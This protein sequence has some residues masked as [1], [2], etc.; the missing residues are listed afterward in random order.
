MKKTFSLVLAL[1]MIFSLFSFGTA[2][3]DF[4]AAAAYEKYAGTELNFIRHSGYEADWMA[5]KAQEFYELSGIKVNVEQIAYSE[6]KNKVML[7]VS[8]PGGAYDI[9]ATTEYWLSEFDEGE[10]LVDQYQFINDPALYDPAFEIEDIGAST[11]DSNTIDGKLLAMPFKTNGQFLVYRSDLV[12]EPPTTWEEYLEIAAANT[13]DDTV[14]VSLALSMASGM[15]V[16]LNLLYQAGGS[17]LNE[18]NTACNLDT[19]EAK[20]AMEFLVNL[21]EYTTEGAINNQWPESSAVFAQGG[22]A[23]Y[24]TINSQLSSLYSSASEEVLSSLKYA[25]LPGQVSCIST[26]GLGITS[27]CECPEAAWL[28]IQYMFGPEK[29]VEVVKGTSGSDIP[30]RSSLLLDKE[31]MSAYPHFEVIDQMLSNEGHT[32]V[33]PKTTV[34]TAIMEALATHVQNA[35]IGS[36]TVDEALANAKAEIDDLLQDA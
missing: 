15:D 33:Y 36:E 14:G 26:W 28:F 18:D 24:P 1:A 16:Y 12:P 2:Y 10:W 3:A 32:W 20:A 35:V 4:D 34:T 11:L 5:E 6:M 8:S 13:N 31:L 22:A 23:L 19:P 29:I 25:E 7:D 9:I 17:F 21:S 27:N 30:I